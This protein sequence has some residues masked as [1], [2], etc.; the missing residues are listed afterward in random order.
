MAAGQ[1]TERIAFDQRAIGETGVRDGDWVEQFVYSAEVTHLVRGETVIASRL[2]GVQ[3]IVVSV[4]RST[5]SRRVTT[6]W[7]ARDVRSGATYNI[8][9]VTPA[10]TRD[11][12]DFLCD[13]GPADG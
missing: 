3:P 4:L 10:K 5:D 6:D 2:Q 1:R 7:R 8:R 9:A 12:I 13:G 11:R